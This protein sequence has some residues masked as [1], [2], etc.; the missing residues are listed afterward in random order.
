MVYEHEAAEEL[1]AKKAAQIRA[2]GPTTVVSANPGCEI[3]LRSQLG[4]SF[5]VIHPVELYWEAL[6]R[7]D[8]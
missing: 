7:S 8:R 4:E 6:D 1:G 2:A 5:R 3:Q